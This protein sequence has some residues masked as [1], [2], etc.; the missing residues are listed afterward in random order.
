MTLNGEP[1]P[2]MYYLTCP[3]LVAALARLEAAGGV[4]RWSSASRKMKPSPR[5][6]ERRRDE[7]RRLRHALAGRTA[8]E[9]RRRFAR[10]RDRRFELA[11]RLKC[12]HAHA[13]FALARPGYLLGERILAEVQP[14]WPTGECCSEALR[15]PSWEGISAKP[16]GRANDSALASQVSLRPR[17]GRC[18]D[19]EARL[20][21][22]A[23][24][25][26]GGCARPRAGGRA[27]PSARGRDDAAAQACWS[28]PSHS[29]SSRPSMQ[30]RRMGARGASQS[31]PFP[32]GRAPCRS[33]RA[34]RSMS[35][36]AAPLTTRRDHA[37][38]GRAEPAALPASRRTVVGR[39]VLI[40]VALLCRSS[41]GSRLRALST[42]GRSAE[43]PTTGVRTLTPLPQE[44]PVRT[45]TVTVTGPSR[46]GAGSSEGRPAYS[47]SDASSTPA[48]M[49]PTAQ[50][51]LIQ[52]PIPRLAK[53]N[54]SGIEMSRRGRGSWRRSRGRS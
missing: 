44:P 7:Q 23:P 42:N 51:R 5:P 21:G 30:C 43:G 1:F 9:G 13:A 50:T 17:D 48:R 36:R 41:S 22:R 52:I 31:A 39:A 34:R 53:K 32:G 4:E 47:S 3:H 40:A 6:L 54:V 12:L 19:R 10:S 20:G 27:S 37:R 2:T 45:V 15:E 16:R 25:P 8:S 29:G 28:E 38:S 46:A 11:G 33:W 18:R 49:I 14:P 26:R 35:T 24:R